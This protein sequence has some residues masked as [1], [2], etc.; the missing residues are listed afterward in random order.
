MC[1]ACSGTHK[2][3]DYK[4]GQE[5][6][7]IRKGYFREI[8]YLLI[9]KSDSS[10]EKLT[11]RFDCECNNWKQGLGKEFKSYYWKA[12]TDTFPKSTFYDSSIIGSVT[13]PR[14]FLAITA[15]E[16]SLLKKAVSLSGEQCC[17]NPNKPVSEI[18]GFVRTDIKVKN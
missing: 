10:N 3:Y 1:V 13:K 9:D 6:I 16:I 7:V 17:D 4:S 8:T 18:I 5:H 15:E 11:L 12:V 2:I 14:V